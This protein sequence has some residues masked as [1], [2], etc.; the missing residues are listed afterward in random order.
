M[1]RLPLLLVISGILTL[2]LVFQATAGSKGTQVLKFNTMTPVVSPFTGSTNP[3][4]GINGGGVPWRQ[5]R[6]QGQGAG[7]RRKRREPRRCLPRGGQLSDAGLADHGRHP[8]E[9]SCSCDERGRREDQGRPCAAD[10][11]PRTDR[12]RDERDRAS[13]RRLVRDYRGRLGRRRTRGEGAALGRAALP[14]W[15]CGVDC[16][17]K[18]RD[19]DARIVRPVDAIGELPAIL[20]WTV[21]AG[22]PTA[23]IRSPARGSSS[24]AAPGRPGADPNRCPGGRPRAASRRP[25]AHSPRALADRDQPRSPLR[26]RLVDPLGV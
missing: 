12:L 1:K 11:V 10:T 24:R 13:T 25:R 15:R 18:G 14:G 8:G 3:V 21:P 16:V 17:R 4:R 20:T 23:S 26:P 6:D 22:S 5:P 7:R 9:R 19:R 2:G